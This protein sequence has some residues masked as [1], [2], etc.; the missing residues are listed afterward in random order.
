[1]D[2]TCKSS[3][4]KLVTNRFINRLIELLQVV[5]GV[6]SKFRSLESELIKEYW[7]FRTIGTSR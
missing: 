3:S 4:I 5:Y 1:M 7:T 2:H 6:L